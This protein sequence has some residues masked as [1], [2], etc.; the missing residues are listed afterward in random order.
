VTQSVQKCPQGVRWR[1]APGSPS[2]LNE[3]RSAS[4]YDT[5]AAA[6]GTVVISWNCC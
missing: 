5:H 3:S 6:I 2:L 1:C 4:V